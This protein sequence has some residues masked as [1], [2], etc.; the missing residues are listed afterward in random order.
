MVT[1]MDGYWRHFSN[2]FNYEKWSR[3]QSDKSTMADIICH[4]CVHF[5]S[6]HHSLSI[7]SST[8]F[9]KNDTEYSSLWLS[10]R[11]NSDWYF[12]GSGQ[13]I[14]WSETTNVGVLTARWQLLYQWSWPL[15][16]NLIKLLI[17]LVKFFSPFC[18]I[19]VIL[20]L[21]LYSSTYTKYYG[22]WEPEP[23]HCKRLWFLCVIQ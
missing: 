19:C 18:I 21:G 1:E 16:W 23:N 8:I 17:F 7:I 12:S 6:P 3:P 11:R 15:K 2:H 22:L 14:E 4:P 10:T 20:Y 13:C 9:K 5:E